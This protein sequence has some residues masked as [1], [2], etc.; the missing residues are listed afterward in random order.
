MMVVTKK[1]KVFQGTFNSFHKALA[2]RMIER[3]DLHE[4]D[5][6]EIGCG[7]GEFLVMLCEL[8]N[9]RGTGFDPGFVDDRIDSS[10]ADRIEFVT[11]FYSEKYASYQGDFLCCKMTLEHIHPTADF[12]KTVRRS[13]GDRLDT[14]IFFQIPDTTR[15]IEDCG[16]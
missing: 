7:K 16:F 14:V 11:D 2:E 10:A 15:I 4:K 6:I 8:G 13:I 1:P 3:Y 9:N 5:I 12:I